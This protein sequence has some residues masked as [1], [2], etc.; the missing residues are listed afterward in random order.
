LLAAGYGTLAWNFRR[1]AD[2]RYGAHTPLTP[3][4]VVDD[5][6]QLMARLAPPRPLLEF[7]RGLG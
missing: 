4:S 6:V 7:A 3:S 5:L 2:T 1:Q